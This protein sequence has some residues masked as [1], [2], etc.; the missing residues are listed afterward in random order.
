MK[1]QFIFKTDEHDCI[2]Y[3]YTV[4]EVS[5]FLNWTVVPLFGYKN[6]IY[7]NGIAFKLF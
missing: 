3:S 6:E 1:R 5:N 4:N 7:F 2:L